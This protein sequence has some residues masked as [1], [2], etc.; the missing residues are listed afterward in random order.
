MSL[1]KSIIGNGSEPIWEAFAK[2]KMGVLKSESGDL[3]VEYSHDD[4]TFKIGNFTHYSTSESVYN[5]TYMIG[6]VE[7]LNPTQFELCLTKEDLI[8]KIRKRFTKKEINLGNR[9]FD[10]AFFIESNQGVTA[11]TILR[12]EQ[13][14]REIAE[15]KPTRI[16]ITNKDGLFGH[17][18]S[19]GYYML[20]YVKKESFRNLEQLNQLHSLLVS[21]ID[22]LKDHCSIK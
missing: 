1:L 14:S 12:D 17:A 11:T 19:T 10:D 13:L 8:T 15:L 3:F 21:F 22:T 7:F 18:P 9:V 4:L 20:Y 5:P 6:I 16:E 2:Q